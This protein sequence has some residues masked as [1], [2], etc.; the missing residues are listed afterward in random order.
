MLR[1]W[2][3]TV[4][5]EGKVLL[6]PKTEEDLG[7]WIAEIEG[8]EGVSSMSHPSGGL[9]VLFIGDGTEIPQFVPEDSVPTLTVRVRRTQDI[10]FTVAEPVREGLQ[11][12]F[13][14]NDGSK[15]FVNKGNTAYALMATP[16]G[17]HLAKRVSAR[18]RGAGASR[19]FRVEEVL[20]HQGETRADI[21]DNFLR[22]A[23][24]FVVAEAREDVPWGQRA[25][26]FYGLHS[27]GFNPHDGRHG[28]KMPGGANYYSG[29][30]KAR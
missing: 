10:G 22:Q 30:P 18:I 1:L 23:L 5:L 12:S 2:E 25:P 24:E 20:I 21:P 3:G 13:R 26:S 28:G 29:P 17:T 11:E 9:Q 16:Y 4:F 15:W 6:H 27:Q 14:G 8:A 7:R 19:V